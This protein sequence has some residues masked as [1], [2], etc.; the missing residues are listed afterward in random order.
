MGYVRWECAVDAVSVWEAE[1]RER[2]HVG[3]LTNRLDVPLAVA[4]FS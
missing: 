1:Y 2:I 4:A 3:Q